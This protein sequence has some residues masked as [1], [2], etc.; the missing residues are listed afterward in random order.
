[1]GWESKP[2]PLLIDVENAYWSKESPLDTRSNPASAAAPGS[3]GSLAAVAR[4]GKVP[5][6]V[7]GLDTQSL[8]GDSDEGLSEGQR[9]E[10]REL[11]PR[12]G[13][14]RGG[15]RNSKRYPSAFFATTLNT[16]LQ[17]KGVETLF[18]YGI[19]TCD[20]VYDT[21]LVTMCYAYR[22]M[23]GRSLGVP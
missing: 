8:K 17:L 3:I 12:A 1:M 11:G 13:A 15:T 21:T 16:R 2:V 19:R 9:D 22:A 14:K 20:Y 7:Y 5:Q 18:I 4:V 23:L 6:S 10:L